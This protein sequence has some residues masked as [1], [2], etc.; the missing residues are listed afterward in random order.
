M[1]R[2]EHPEYLWALLFLPVLA[3]LYLYYWRWR[4]KSIQRFGNH[5][6]MQILMPEASR[7]KHPIKFVLLLLAF[8][9]LIVGWANPQWGTK[10]EKAQR[11]SAD[12]FIVLDISNSMLATDVAPNR[13]E[14]AKRLAEDLTEKLKGEKIGLILFAGNAYLQMPLTT[15]YAA[16]KMFI[17]SATTDLAST[18]GTAI[19]EAIATARR[20]FQENKDYHK[21][22]ILL[23]DGEDHEGSTIEQINKAKDEGI[24]LFTVGVG[25]EAGSFIPVDF[26][27]RQEYKRNDKGEPVRS[28]LNS[29]MLKDLTARGGG[30][31]YHISQSSQI[32]N[33][34]REKIDEMDKMELETRA[35]SD[36][37]SYFK[38]FLIVALTLLL[39]E[40][41][42]SYRR[43]KWLEG[44]DFFG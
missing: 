4:K 34:L 1:F 26:G 12:V 38:Y 8:G 20:S 42:I 44:K 14:R 24:V 32:P 39:V 35:F 30:T 5:R 40:F 25:S 23:T 6:L 19:G 22:L 17:G 7:W 36:Y 16:A 11:K 33:A 27:G 41:L 37:E 10:R 13:L 31:Y 43:E 28:K 2:F 18:Q 21:A 9:F 15:D 3:A 29:T